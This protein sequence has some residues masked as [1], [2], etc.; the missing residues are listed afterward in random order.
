[1]K[2]TKFDLRLHAFEA[3][4]PRWVFWEVSDNSFFACEQKSGR[5]NKSESIPQYCTNK[6]ITSR[7]NKPG[8]EFSNKKW[9]TNNHRSGNR[10]NWCRMKWREKRTSISRSPL[11][12]PISVVGE[13]YGNLI[14]AASNYCGREK[15]K[16]LQ[17][18]KNGSEIESNRWESGNVVKNQ[19]IYRFILG[20]LS[21][22]EFGN[23]DRKTKFCE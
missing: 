17:Q 3:I 4:F 19:S 15:K 18:N 7:Q 6:I 12:K 16:M 11:T 13:L 20:M 14:P 2:R 9:S 23:K 21:I 10:A 1:M 22:V 5:Q 8:T